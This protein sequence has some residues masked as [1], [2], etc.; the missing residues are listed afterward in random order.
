MLSVVCS[1]VV[2]F[3]VNCKKFKHK[4]YNY[5]D[6][7]IEITI[8]SFSKSVFRYESIRVHWNETVYLVIEHRYYRINHMT[9]CILIIF[10]IHIDWFYI[11]DLFRFIFYR[12]N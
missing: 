3:S 2:Y 11:F 9:D 10:L 4:D 7:L 12:T 8:F 5:Y 6:L 1:T